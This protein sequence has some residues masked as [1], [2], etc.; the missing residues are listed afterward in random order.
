MDSSQ[1]RRAGDK[2]CSLRSKS[3]SSNDIVAPCVVLMHEPLGGKVDQLSGVVVIE[4]DDLLGGGIGPKFH[5]A[6]KKES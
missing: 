5:H 1:V 3:S 6:I 4:T 2:R